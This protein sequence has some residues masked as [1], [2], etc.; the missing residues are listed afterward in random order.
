MGIRVFNLRNVPEDEADDIRHLLT[1]Q[2]IEFY[3]TTSGMLGLFTPAIW[4]QDK[5]Q[6]ELAQQLLADYQ[7]Q[8]GEL[9]RQQYADELAEGRQRTFLHIVKENPLRVIGYILVILLILYFSIKPFF[10]LL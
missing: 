10:G 6:L 1:E 9:A 3:E 5:N 4:L 8:R 7:R 2:N